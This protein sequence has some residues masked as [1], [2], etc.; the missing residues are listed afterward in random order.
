[1][2]NLV[3][4]KKDYPIDKERSV[5]ALKGIN[6]EF[7]D[8]GFISILG[9]SGCGKTTLLN[10]LGGLDR[11]T[12]GDLIVDNKS[13]K[14][15]DDKDWDNYRNKKIGMVF[16]S[17]N[18]IGH[19]SVL[20][21]VEVALTLSGVERSVRKQLSIEALKSVGLESEI[22]KF[23]NQLSGGQ[24]QRVALARAIVNNPSVVLADEPTGALDSVTSVQIMNI[25]AE[26][27]STRL[28][29]MV[30]HNKQL[31]LDYSSRIIE[32]KDGEILKDY[33]NTP[34]F[35]K[36]VKEVKKEEENT[37][38]TMISS[39]FKSEVKKGLKDVKIKK[40][41][42]SMSFLTALS[43]SLQSI[44][45]KK[46][47]T[48][49]TSIAGSFGIIGV[50]LV[51]SLSNG[52]T[53]YISD[54]QS[55]TL[56]Q[57]PISVE[58]YSTDYT[59]RESKTEFPD[60]HSVI[61]NVPNTSVHVNNITQ[62]YINYV[63]DMDEK[64]TS[65]INYNYALQTNVLTSDTSGNISVLN[66][67]SSSFVSSLL[68]S[69]SSCWYELPSSKDFVL[70]KYDLIEG[71]Y[72]SSKNEAVLV[73]D[74]YN[75]LSQSTLKTLGFDTTQESIDVTTILNKEFKLVSNDNFYTQEGTISVTGK[76]LK[77]DLNSETYPISKLLEYYQGY[78]Q[79]RKDGDSDL[80][81]ED[82]D[83]IKSYFN[84]SS[85]TKDIPYYSSADSD[86][87][88][89]KSVYTNKSDSVKIVG[90][91]RPNNTSVASILSNGIYC[92][93]E[94]VQSAIEV[95]KTSKIAESYKNNIIL[96]DAVYPD[97]S[98]YRELQA[99]VPALQSTPYDIT[100]IS[101]YISKRK[102]YGTDITVSSISIYPKDFS[103]KKDILNYLDA[104]NTDKAETNQVRYTDLATTVFT[105][106]ETMVNMISTVL[107]AFASISLVVSSVMIGIIIYNSVI[108]RTKEIGILRAIGARKKDV[109]RLF[110]AEACILGL[111]SGT[112]GVLVTYILC[113][114]L[115]AIFNSMNLGLDL[116][117]LASLNPLHA[118]FL[119]ALSVVLNYI[120]SLI[121]SRMASK[122]D[123]VIAL[124]TE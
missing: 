5:H 122:K 26:I 67:A 83:K 9:P 16:Q 47:R 107:V 87:D 31:A 46:G 8:T 120:A 34:S 75:S 52:F 103:Y 11:Y 74:K 53:N 71:S 39:D 70:S 2:L 45:S 95:N 61:V 81:S 25:L 73:V 98:I 80:M 69:T 1:M 97:I 96:N 64:Y 89:L 101:S 55:E 84:D 13:T 72:P 86:T 93:S 60:D 33:Q 10:I 22:H 24:M 110:K 88:F 59:Q 90:I 44:R 23:P 57:F 82:L 7:P 18:L 68:S 35:K 14:E 20:G 119:I 50:A 117:H 17:Y 30:T 12:S 43:I 76:F 116:S 40:K 105:S 79:A 32:I 36:E 48:A 49:L 6:V 123:P 111:F 114:P 21:N 113:F 63:K 28:V 3:D 65:S 94:F 109:S 15:F 51:L 78:V 37:D 99:T 4:I 62:D 124:R 41:K 108:E 19:M 102:L 66:T 29:L 91:L 92:K 104:Y 85:E 27:A 42:S 56:A 77:S 121:P 118:L 58:E 112:F 38:L 54:M 115:N 106:L 100:Y